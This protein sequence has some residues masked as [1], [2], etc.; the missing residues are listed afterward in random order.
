MYFFYIW[1]YSVYPTPYTFI[2]GILQSMQLLGGFV[3]Q[4]PQCDWSG[5][6]AKGEVEVRAAPRHPL[7]V[8]TA[9]ISVYSEYSLLSPLTV[10]AS[11]QLL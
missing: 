1:V 11:K 2:L 6:P 8:Y 9:D 3:L 4:V 5:G 7:T 10:L